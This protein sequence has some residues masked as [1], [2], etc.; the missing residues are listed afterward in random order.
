MTAIAPPGYRP[1]YAR[2]MRPRRPRH[3]LR[4]AA[5]LAVLLPAAA[6]AADPP[7][8]PPDTGHGFRV[9]TRPPPAPPDPAPDARAEVRVFRD[10][11]DGPGHGQGHRPG[12]RDGTPIA[13][14]VGVGLTTC[15]D[16]TTQVKSLDAGGW[17]L[18]V[19]SPCRED[20]APGET[21]VQGAAGTTTP[22]AGTRPPG[23]ARETG[24]CDPATWDC[25]APAPTP[26]TPPSPPPR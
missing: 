17:P 9:G 2:P 4:A 25:T 5:L 16:G 20:R 14:D 24:R 15:A 19:E 12:H 13:V 22:V 1:V 7:A 10:V 3:S 6:L 11:E 8:P 26:S 23:A 21:R 18:E